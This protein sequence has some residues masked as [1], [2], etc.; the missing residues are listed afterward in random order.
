MSE[1]PHD[2][3]PSDIEFFGI[4]LKVRDPRL[5]RLLNSDVSENVVVIGRRTVDL[6]ARA[7]EDGE[8]GSQDDPS[9]HTG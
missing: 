5:A 6:L 8:S 2:M 3:D 1:R 9:P 4:K 7:D